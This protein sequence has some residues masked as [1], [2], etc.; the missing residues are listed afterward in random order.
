[1]TLLAAIPNP[2]EILVTTSSGKRF[3]FLSLLLTLGGVFSLHSHLIRSKCT[4]DSLAYSVVY[5]LHN[6]F[7][8]N[9]W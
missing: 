1:M 7:F 2:N 9:F 5:L 3:F 8:L 4:F 6:I